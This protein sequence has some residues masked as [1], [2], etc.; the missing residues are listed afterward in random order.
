MK[1]IHGTHGITPMRKA[2]ES[3]NRKEVIAALSED[4]DQL[5][6]TLGKYEIQSRILAIHI[7]NAIRILKEDSHK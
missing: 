2:A 1:Q 7:R 3:M 4:A 5:E 6:S